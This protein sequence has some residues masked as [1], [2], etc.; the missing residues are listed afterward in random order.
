MASTQKRTT[1]DQEE[2]EKRDETFCCDTDFC[3]SS[4]KPIL[5]SWL[6]TTAHWVTEG[7]LSN[8][9][10]AERPC[11]A[12][13]CAL[14]IAPLHTL[15][16][17]SLFSLD[18]LHFVGVM[19]GLRGSWALWTSRDPVGATSFNMARCLTDID[20]DIVSL[21]DQEGDVNDGSQCPICLLAL[22]MP[23][24]LPCCGNLFCFECSWCRINRCAMCRTPVPREFWDKPEEFLISPLPEP[25]TQFS[26]I[27]KTRAG[28]W[29][30]T[31]RQEQAIRR[32]LRSGT[33]E[34]K[35][36]MA[37]KEA[38]LDFKSLLIKQNLKVGAITIARNGDRKVTAVTPL[39]AGNIQA[40]LLPKKTD[41]KA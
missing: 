13:H 8:M 18:S 5:S 22:E 2:Y 9:S 14:S 41:K 24:R 26:W 39:L 16:S 37:G 21:E 27:F 29:H 12:S 10:A 19:A 34:L 20:E 35:L 33:P 1:W 17:V 36:T 15:L 23:L 31:P 11:V 4:Q 32:T 38:T 40:V 30:F 7:V 3:N 28:W 25:A 6:R